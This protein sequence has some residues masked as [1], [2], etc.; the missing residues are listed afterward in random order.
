MN[1]RIIHGPSVDVNQKHFGE[2]EVA[3]ILASNSAQGSMVTLSKVGLLLFSSWQ[4]YLKYQPDDILSDV[5]HFKS[6]FAFYLKNKWTINQAWIDFQKII[7]FHTDVIMH[8]AGING[9][10][11]PNFSVSLMTYEIFR[12]LLI[13]TSQSQEIGIGEAIRLTNF[14]PEAV[15]VLLNDQPSGELSEDDIITQSADLM[16]LIDDSVHYTSDQIE[17]FQRD[18]TASFENMGLVPLGKKGLENM[19]QSALKEYISLN[20]T[21]QKGEDIEFYKNKIHGGQNHKGNVYY[22]LSIAVSDQM[23][24]NLKSLLTSLR[25]SRKLTQFINMK[26]FADQMQV[27]GFHF[28]E[29]VLDFQ[30]WT[31]KYGK[32][33]PGYS[34]R[35][36]ILL[37]VVHGLK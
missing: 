15:D 3:Q 29:L 16:P 22:Q 4:T 5:P 21:F 11:I 12:L 34:T 20:F 19:L 2:G 33:K 23:G 35:N 10:N 13:E 6:R 26:L 17:I 30:I 27:P 37:N 36:G 28:Y 32:E 14:V 9:F 24:E 31:P 7:T 8:Q 25:D 1:K 18:M